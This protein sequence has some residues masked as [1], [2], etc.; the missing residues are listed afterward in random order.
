MPLTGYELFEN[1]NILKATQGYRRYCAGGV[2]LYIPGFWLG[3]DKS[4]RKCWCVEAAK[5]VAIQ[6]S[7]RVKVVKL[8][9]NARGRWCVL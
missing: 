7:Q 4:D 6:T 8:D 1:W 5:L 2:E 3:L 9:V